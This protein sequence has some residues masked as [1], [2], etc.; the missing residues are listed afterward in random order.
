MINHR[1]FSILIVVSTIGILLIIVIGLSTTYLRELRLSRA[2][3]DDVLS[4]SAAEWMFEYG[5]LKIRNHREGFE[6]SVS[7]TTIDGREN[8]TYVTD[9]SKNLKTS[10]TIRATSTG[11]V[12]SVLPSEHLILPLFIANKTLISGT[13]ASPL[14]S[15]GIIKTSWL[16]I[17]G[18]GGDQTWT[19]VGT[20]W[21]E[22]IGMNGTGGIDENSLGTIRKEYFQC[23]DSSGND[24]D[25]TF[26]GVIEK[27]PYFADSTKKVSDFLENMQDTYFLLYNPS[28][29]LLNIRVESFTPFSL[30]NPS[31]EARAMKNQSS[32]V[33]QFTDDRG[34]Y[35]DAL[36]YWVYNTD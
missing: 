22:T 20:Q 4:Y 19:L 2:S 6:D 18:I 33:F 24:M 8:F 29:T 23:F 16:R 9:R 15:T 5:M 31:I 3:Y 34:R 12:F 32:Q 13:S 36:K 30:P 10:Y 35:Y 17:S 28:D 7:E 11:E 26:P 27:I 21:G 14:S 1:G 25:C